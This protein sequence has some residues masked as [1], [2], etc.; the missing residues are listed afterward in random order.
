MDSFSREKIE[1]KVEV[2]V[3]KGFRLEH[4][5][6]EMKITLQEF[7]RNSEKTFLLCATRSEQQHQIVEPS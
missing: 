7:I 4:L 3:P 2:S 1:G 6:A 5:K